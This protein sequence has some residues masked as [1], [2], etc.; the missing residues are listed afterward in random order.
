MKRILL[1]SA[2]MLTAS[3]HRDSFTCSPSTES[4]N[5]SCWGFSE[6]FGTTADASAFTPVFSI[7]A[8]ASMSCPYP[9]STI[10][11]RYVDASYSGAYID[12]AVRIGETEVAWAWGA[13]DSSGQLIDG[14]YGYD[15]QAV[16]YYGCWSPSAYIN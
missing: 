15:S 4:G 12:A 3:A 6:G 10:A 7:Y 1:V 14:E 16:Q 8:H 11:S 9:L 13:V 5:Y 2:L